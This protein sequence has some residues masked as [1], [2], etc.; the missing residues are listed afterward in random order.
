MANKEFSSI[1]GA[2]GVESTARIAGSSILSGNRPGRQPAAP[3][4]G[5]PAGCRHRSGFGERRAV[6]KP[7]KR[8][9]PL[10]T[11]RTKQRTAGQLRKISSDRTAGRRLGSWRTTILFSDLILRRPWARRGSGR[12]RSR[13]QGA[14]A[15]PG[16]APMR[17]RRRRGQP[18]RDRRASPATARRRQAARGGGEGSTARP[19]RPALPADR[20][21]GSHSKHLPMG[22]RCRNADFGVWK[23]TI[24]G[25]RIIG[26]EIRTG[27]LTY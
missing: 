16:R 26:H 6:A 14:P 24:R 25:Y 27:L 13:P 17:R 1:A 15:S 5:G 19:R 23:H 22:R 3:C 9:E 11:K 20:Q 21:P 18:C 10:N 12:F 2:A 8:S 7:S 4:D